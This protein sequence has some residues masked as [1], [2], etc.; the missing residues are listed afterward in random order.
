M[1]KVFLIFN[2][3]SKVGLIFLINLFLYQMAF[4]DEILLKNGDRI[5]GRILEMDPTALVFSTKYAKEIKIDLSEVRNVL[6]T[7]PVEIHMKNGWS[8]KGNILPSKNGMMRVKPKNGKESALIEWKKVASINAPQKKEAKW[9]GKFS[10]GASQQQGNVDRATYTIGGEGGLHLGKD[11]FGLRFLTFYA[12]D[13][14]DVTARNTFGKFSFKHFFGK[15]WYWNMNAEG[16]KDT[17]KNLN[18]RLSIGPGAGFQ[19]WNDLK[20]KL[21]IEAGVTYFS[22]DLK[23]GNDKQ[24]SSARMAGDFSYHFTDSL[25]FNNNFVVYPSLEN[26]DEYILRNQASIS[27]KI[28]AGWALQLTHIFDYNNNPATGIQKDDFNTVLGLQYDF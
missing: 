24:Y 3:I 16:Y 15:K 1:R 4:A 13:N 14:G 11:E 5:K 28:G 19:I 27:Q 18:L 10:L 17:F 21:S 20:K 9:S 26:T 8:L 23:Q 2:E 25:N 7:K 12:E 6:T 22:E